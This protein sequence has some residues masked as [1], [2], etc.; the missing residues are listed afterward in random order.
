MLA[1]TAHAPFAHELERRR[2]REMERIAHVTADQ[3]GL[4]EAGQL[5]HPAADRKHAGVAVADD[6]P[7]RRRR[8]IVLE[9]LEEEAE[10]AVATLGDV[11][12]EPLVPVDVDGSL[13]AV[14]ADE[15]GHQTILC[16]ARL[17]PR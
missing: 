10:A 1:E 3:V 5:E 12:R 6:E 7:C 15:D 14:R 13:T 4:P 17:R 16:P 9:E 11:R 2:V 8:V